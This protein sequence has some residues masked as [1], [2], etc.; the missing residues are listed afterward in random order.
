VK[1]F[2]PAIDVD[3]GYKGRGNDH[4]TGQGYADIVAAIASADMRRIFQE[5]DRAVQ[6]ELPGGVTGH[7]REAVDHFWL[8]LRAALPDATFE[9]HHVIGRN[10]PEFSPRA[11]LRWSLT[12]KHSGWG[13]FGTPTGADIHVMGMSQAEFGP[14]GLRREWILIDETAIWKQILLHTG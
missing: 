4:P 5:Y 6:V 14:W 9:I 3:G 1:P 10:D 7:G 12:G 2:T 8:N 11:A 13:M